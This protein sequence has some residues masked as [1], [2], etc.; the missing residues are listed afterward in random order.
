MKYRFLEHTADIKF[1]SAGKTLDEVFENAVLAVS[2]YLSRGSQ[3]KPA[4][5]KIISVSGTDMESLF[6]NFLD[7]L[8]YLLDAENFVVA[9]AKVTI[10]GFNLHAELFGDKASNYK[11][12]DHIKAATYAEMFIKKTKSG[13]KAQA[14]LD[15]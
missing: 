11:D 4:K 15:V 5:G 14:V 3:I 10:R 8:I 7:E 9:K 6:Y 2:N 12:L 1:Q 13:W